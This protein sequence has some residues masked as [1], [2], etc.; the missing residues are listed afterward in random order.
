MSSAYKTYTRLSFLMSV[1]ER[2][3]KKINAAITDVPI[4]INLF[5]LTPETSACDYS[6]LQVSILLG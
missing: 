6:R 4:K 5:T 1:L 3:E 2:K